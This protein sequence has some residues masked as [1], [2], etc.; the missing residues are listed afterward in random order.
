MSTDRRQSQKLKL[1][2]RIVC[3]SALSKLNTLQTQAFFA[4]QI[5]AHKILKTFL[6]QLQNYEKCRGLTYSVK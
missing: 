4:D 2:S 5:Q 1:I 6:Q 3:F